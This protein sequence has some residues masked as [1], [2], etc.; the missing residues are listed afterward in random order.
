MA[1]LNYLNEPE[2]FLN[3]LRKLNTNQ[4]LEELE[5]LESLLVKNKCAHFKDCVV[6]ARNNF[7]EFFSNIIKQ[8]LFNFPENLK[9]EAGLP[10]WLE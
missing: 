3:N 5:K 9:T 10:F 8:L 1:T 7:E 2:K 6:W 4:Q